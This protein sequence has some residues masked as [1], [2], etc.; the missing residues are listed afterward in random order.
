MASM[1]TRLNIEKLD[2]NIIQKMRFTKS[3][4][5]QL[6]PGVETGVHGVHDEKRVWFEVELQ[7]A[8]GDHEAEV[9]QVSNDDTAVA[10]RWS[11]QQCTKSRVA[12]HLGVAGLQQQNGLVKETN[13]TLLA[14]V[15]CFL[16][17]SATGFKTP[18]DMLGFFGW[19]ASIKQGMLE[20]VKVKCISGIRKK[21]MIL[22]KPDVATSSESNEEDN[23][24]DV[25]N[26]GS[27]SNV[28]C[29]VN[30]KKENIPPSDKAICDMNRLVLKSMWKNSQF[31]YVVKNSDE[32]SRGIVAI[33]DNTLFTLSSSLG[34][35]GFLA[36]VG[37]WYN[38][39]I[40]CLFIIV[41]APQ[42]QRHKRKLWKDITQLISIHNTLTILPGDFNEVWN[43]DERKG[44]MFDLRG[45][46]RFDNFISSSSLVDLPMGAK[47]F[48][49][50]NN[51]GNKLSKIH[52]VLVSQH[53]ID[54]WP[55]SHTVA[56]PGEFSD[57]TPILLSNMTTDF[58]PSPFKLQN[59]KNIIKQWRRKVRE[60]ENLALVELRKMVDCLDM[61]AEL[62]FLNDDVRYIIHFSQ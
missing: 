25:G 23:T 45:D 15:R 29:G 14:K 34:G 50:M 2:G 55:G 24:I 20:L 61:K 12:K 22:S 59:L 16:I 7:G 38:I 8:Q 48:T 26:E 42:D 11:T 28:V 39:N 41:Y 62:S 18:I 4:F 10:Q 44:T 49:R 9:F 33:W 40:P 17:Q 3:G 43:V 13:V 5:K 58:R 57:H 56:L 51:L 36:I 46:S 30:D 1:N 35:D 60:T 21:A 53:V 54:L 37:N 52:R 31:D 6:G 27:T 19:L 47:R 32:N